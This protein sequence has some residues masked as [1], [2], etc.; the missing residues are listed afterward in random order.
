MSFSDSRESEKERESE[1]FVCLFVG[2]LNG[3]TSERVIGGFV[4]VR[5]SGKE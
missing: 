3:A 4:S 2:V 5:F 1:G